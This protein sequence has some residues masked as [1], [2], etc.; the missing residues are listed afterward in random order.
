MASVE[1]W[2][3]GELAALVERYPSLCIDLNGRSF[4]GG[5]QTFESW[6]MNAEMR[7]DFLP[8]DEQKTVAKQIGEFLKGN[9]VQHIRVVG[10]PGLG[11]TR[12]V[13]EA[14]RAEPTLSGA[15]VYA[16]QAGDFQDSR[17]FNELLKQDRAYRAVL[18]I[19]DCDE[20]E[21]ASI[22]GRLKG[23]H[24][25]KIITIDHGPDGSADS[26]MEVV[27]M[28]PLGD[29]EIKGILERYVGPSSDLHHWVP[30]CEGSPRVAHALGENLSNNPGDLL[31]SPAT[32]DIWG[33][34]IDGY[35]GGERADE[36]RLV[37][38]HLSLFRKFGFRPPVSDEADFIAKL[39]QKADPQITRR[40]FDRIV[41]NLTR[42]RILQGG[43]TLRIV[44]K[45]LHIYLWRDWWINQGQSEDLAALLEEV[46]VSLKRW[47]SEMLIYASGAAP[48]QDA[49][50]RGLRNG[51]L[52]S[53]APITTS[54]GAEFYNILAEA[55]P[56][57][58]AAALEVG[59]GNLATAEIQQLDSSRQQ[60][61]SALCKLAVHRRHFGR[62]ARLLAKLTYGEKSSFSNNS[63]GSFCELFQLNMGPTQAPPSERIEVL[64]DLFAGTEHDRYLALEAS[65][66]LLN[67]GSHIRVVGV[68][69]QGIGPALKFWPLNLAEV[70]VA[71]CDGLALLEQQA[72]AHD[73]EWQ[74]RLSDA[75]IE[76]AM[77]M[78]RFPDLEQTALGTLRRQVAFPG[79]NL[80][81][82]AQRIVTRVRHRFHDLPQSTVDQLQQILDGLGTGSFQRRFDRF[83]CFETYEESYRRVGNDE[84]ADDPT[85]AKR[86]EELAREFAG[87]VE[88]SSEDVA[89]VLCASGY[90][91]REFGIE[92]AKLTNQLQDWLVGM[93]GVAA[94]PSTNFQFMMG[95]LEHLFKAERARWTHLAT[96]MLEG[97]PGP[98]QARTVVFSGVCPE[99][100]ARV[101]ALVR[102][103]V[104]D[105][106]LLKNWAW[107]FHEN[108]LTG[109]E[110]ATIIRALLRDKHQRA[111]L[112][113]LELVH[114]WTIVARRELDDELVWAVLADTRV[115]T[116]R[117]DSS[118]GHH[119]Q[120]LAK[121]YIRRT[122]ENDVAVFEA[123]VDLARRSRVDTMSPMFETAAELGFAAPTRIWPLL[124]KRL[125]DRQQ[126]A[127]L[128]YWLGE[129]RTDDGGMP[130]LAFDPVDVLSWIANDISTRA[131]LMVDALPRTLEGDLG[132]LTR[133]FL[134]R[135]GDDP[136][137]RTGLIWRFRLGMS[138]G[139]LSLTLRR[140]R[141]A[142]RGWLS[143]TESSNV[144]RWIEEF[145]EEM[146]ERSEEAKIEEER[147]R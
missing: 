136:V 98:W 90:R 91:L 50:R 41:A 31:R 12:L 21:R 132:N 125:G 40:R 83:V 62:A 44:P 113:A 63:R 143:T 37:L 112:V 53:A 42:K 146:S 129:G 6:S 108:A 25:L 16:P 11:K 93:I 141:D 1:V 106:D 27:I 135:F 15:T 142:A 23:R 114:S 70:F 128:A 19:D 55:D 104:V 123:V 46:P 58:A 124:A 111:A 49:I 66:N 33:R 65:G 78:L 59:I 34:F 103:G 43:H 35:K 51:S 47:F 56:D 9:S 76:A 45:A 96:A 95:Y 28:P 82:L 119:W 105:V 109:P 138:V 133:G 57:S 4:D 22:Y 2:G 115:L 86:V 7:T 131:K 99:I 72:R 26:T 17:L 137:L 144:R 13:L 18:V 64:E 8:G 52:A 67:S 139:P 117:L 3:T 130:I 84:L 122:P 24:D 20:A 73:Q 75:L 48:A 140:K 80:N 100:A 120:R 87:L 30:W 38:E 60:L 32:V 71:W 89:Y 69:H 107:S 14:L 36:T 74:K 77:G 29:A 88:E 134:D 121:D 61:S 116:A 126:A 127:N 5:L 92:V 118:A 101:L 145:I 94:E 54:G 110:L 97:E 68:E 102:T 81:G 85:P 79:A 39:I 10:E 147:G